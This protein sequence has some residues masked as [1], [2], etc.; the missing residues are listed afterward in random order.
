MSIAPALAAGGWAAL[1]AQLPS[2]AAGGYSPRHGG[3]GELD[4]EDAV[5]IEPMIGI[6]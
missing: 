5:V 1:K 2:A 3:M 4:A 6:G